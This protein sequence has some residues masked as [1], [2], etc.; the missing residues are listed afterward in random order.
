MKKKKVTPSHRT[1]YKKEIQILS[2]ILTLLVGIFIY[3]IYRD[4]ILL[5]S[6]LKKQNLFQIIHY[7]KSL[8]IDDII[9]LNEFIIYSFP[10]FCWLFSYNTFL[11]VI[12]RN[13]LKKIIIFSS[14]LSLPTLIIE[15][16]QLFRIDDGVFDIY[17]IIC[18]LSGTLAPNFI[19][20][21]KFK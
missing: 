18:I 9:V 16:L 20:N 21:E 4:N 5:F 13:N 3:I 2:A 7:L 17:D 8:K 10:T 19:W 6:V 15:L 11:V 14:L 12:W 1:I